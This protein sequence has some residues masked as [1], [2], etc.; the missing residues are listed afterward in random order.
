MQIQKQ[1]IKQKIVATLVVLFMFVM[2]FGS[3]SVDFTSA[4]GTNTTLI[5]NLIAGALSMEAPATLAFNNQTLGVAANSLANMDVVNARDLRGTGVA[6]TVT[7]SMNNLTTGG[8]GVNN[9]SN[10][11]IAWAP[12][13]AFADN[14]SNTGTAVGT[15]GYFST[16]R[17]LFNTSTNNGMGNYKITNTTVNVVFNG[18]PNFVAGTYQNTMTMTIQ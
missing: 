6:W 15:A 9:I 4:I 12:G 16:L 14:G 7:A 17:T 5:Q 8:A 10:A 3:V 18:N 11:A 1:K 2:V 13:A